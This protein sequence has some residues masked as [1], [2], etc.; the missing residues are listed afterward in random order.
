V[1]AF[2]LR[3]YYNW[4]FTRVIANVWLHR[5]RINPLPPF[6]MLHNDLVFHDIEDAMNTYHGLILHPWII[7]APEVHNTSYQN[8]MP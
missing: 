4:K 2:L 6:A 5:R 8:I 7:S 1:R 3:G